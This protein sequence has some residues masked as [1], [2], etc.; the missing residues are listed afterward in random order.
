MLSKQPEDIQAVDMSYYI[1]FIPSEWWKEELVFCRG[2][3]LLGDQHLKTHLIFMEIWGKPCPLQI[4]P[5]L[6]LQLQ[7]LFH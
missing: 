6:S 1:L 7:A 4:I 3:P 2:L 5:V